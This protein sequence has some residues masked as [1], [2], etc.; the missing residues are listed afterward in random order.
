MSSTFG[1]KLDDTT[2]A[3]L[4]A[5]AQRIMEEDPVIAGF[6]VLRVA[7]RFQGIAVDRQNKLSDGRLALARMI[8]GDDTS[9]EAHLAL[10]ELANGICGPQ[11]PECGHCPLEPWC[12]EAS[13]IDVQ[14]T[15]PLTSPGRRRR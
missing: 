4:E 11:R 15:L 5:A 1:V 7:A 10:I 8:G 2:R 3:R 12:Q 9:H 13:E 6:G 14:P